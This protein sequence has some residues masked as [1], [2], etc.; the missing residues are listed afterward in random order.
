MLM[1]E[2][3]PLAR[4]ETDGMTVGDGQACPRSP[5]RPASA[6]AVLAPSARGARRSDGAPAVSDSPQAIS[7]PTKKASAHRQQR[8][9]AGAGS[10]MAERGPEA[11]S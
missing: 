8:R 5:R 7:V 10:R 9:V 1:A 2:A 4:D 3:V 11:V 6:T